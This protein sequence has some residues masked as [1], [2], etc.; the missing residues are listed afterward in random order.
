[1]RFVNIGQK[2][3]NYLPENTTWAKQSIAHNTMVLDPK[4]HFDGKYARVVSTSTLVYAA[5]EDE[6]LLTLY[7]EE[8]NAY[9]SA[10]LARALSLVSLSE[11]DRPLLVDL[12]TVSGGA[13]TIDVP[14]HYLGQFI[15]ISEPLIAPST[16]VSL[17]TDNGYQHI[18][19]EARTEAVSGAALKFTWLNANRFYTMFRSAKPGDIFFHGRAGANDPDFNLRRDPY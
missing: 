6:S 13:K 9:P 5:L 18:L 3:G 12:V 19:E 17:G 10:K 11:L 7:A 14:T 15:E 16:L 4:S 1:M 2:G 8:I